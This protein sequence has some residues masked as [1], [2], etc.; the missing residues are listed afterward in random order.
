VQFII[1]MKWGFSIVST[2]V[3]NIFGINVEFFKILIVFIILDYISGI[4]SSIV[5]K[6][7]SSDIGFK[8]ILKKIMMIIV[9]SVCQILSHYLIEDHQV[10]G[11]VV[12]FFYISNEC[13]SILEN[14]ATMGLP[15]PNS[16]VE[17]LM[18]FKED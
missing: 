14:A 10:I 1:F 2:L 17:I 13:I 7:L 5:N 6:K 3:T 4:L 11:T 18:R 12:I 16:I 8:G 9:V 15:I